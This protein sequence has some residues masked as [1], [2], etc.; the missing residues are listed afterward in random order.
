M[1]EPAKSDLK[2]VNRNKDDAVG[3]WNSTQRRT[4]NTQK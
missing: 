4:S 2:V 3:S 1:L